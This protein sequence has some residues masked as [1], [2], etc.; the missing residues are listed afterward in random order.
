MLVMTSAWLCVLE[1]SGLTQCIV[2]CYHGSC[3]KLWNA[4]FQVTLMSLC[5]ALHPIAPHHDFITGTHACVNVIGLM[6]LYGEGL[7]EVIHK[8]GIKFRLSCIV[9]VCPVACHDMSALQ[10]VHFTAIMPQQNPS[11]A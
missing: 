10:P 9:L 6:Q 11:L 1:G 2:A 8:A 4:L 7:G 5:C 3:L